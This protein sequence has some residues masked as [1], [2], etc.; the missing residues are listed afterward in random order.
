MSN[1]ADSGRT[2]A[3]AGCKQRSDHF[4]ATI[5]C[6]HVSSGTV[7][8]SVVT[9]VENI[10]IKRANVRRDSAQ[11][12]KRQGRDWTVTRPPSLQNQEPSS[13]I[14]LVADGLQLPGDDRLP[15][16]VL[17]WLQQETSTTQED[18]TIFK[19]DYTVFIRYGN[20]WVLILE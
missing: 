13:I 12:S 18:L 19:G 16:R 11:P 20:K 3:S 15:G 6:F 2:I 7:P 17:S 4:V 8:S 1:Y 14:F 5:E 10:V 9:Q